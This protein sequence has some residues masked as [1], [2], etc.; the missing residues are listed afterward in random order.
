MS[1]T[2]RIKLRLKCRVGPIGN[3]REVILYLLGNVLVHQPANGPFR[4]PEVRLTESQCRIKMRV[5]LTERSK[6][7]NC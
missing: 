3:E 5:S 7:S 1:L 2:Q 4:D 6:A